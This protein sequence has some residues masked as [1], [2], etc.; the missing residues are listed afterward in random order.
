MAVTWDCKVELHANKALFHTR[1]DEVRDWLEDHTRATRWGTA[2]V[3]E[4]STVSEV[5]NRMRQDGYKV[6]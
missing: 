2:Y 3:L 1:T 6:E 4:G 5:V